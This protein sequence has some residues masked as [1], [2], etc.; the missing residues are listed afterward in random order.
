[1]TRSD[2]TK[3]DKPSTK[4]AERVRSDRTRAD[5]LT[6][7]TDDA[8]VETSANSPDAERK[9][10]RD[11]AARTAEGVEDESRLI[12]VDANRVEFTMVDESAGTLSATARRVTDPA[13]TDEVP[14]DL[15]KVDPN[16]VRFA[17]IDPSNG[18]QP[19]VQREPLR[20]ALGIEIPAVSPP[21][22]FRQKK[23]NDAQK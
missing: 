9:R 20:D 11:A 18:P 2:T 13:T 16:K 4:D 21:E 8:S 12:E 6:E 3:P 1:M 23:G 15:I 10:L 14:Q 7:R 22:A 19:V 5:A 17:S